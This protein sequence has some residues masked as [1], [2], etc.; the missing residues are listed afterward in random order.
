MQQRTRSDTPNDDRPDSVGLFQ[1]GRAADEWE[2]DAVASHLHGLPS[3]PRTV[4]TEALL[5]FIC[6]EDREHVAEAL[7]ALGGDRMRIHYRVPAGD[8]GVRH[9]VAVAHLASRPDARPHAQGHVIEIT[10]DLHAASEQASRKAVAGVVEGRGAI[11]QAKGV[12]MLA[13]GL[14]DDQ[15]FSLLRWWSRNRNIRIRALA[16]LL[17]AAVGT[18]IYSSQELRTAFDRFMHD[19]TTV[20]GGMEAGGD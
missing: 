3:R 9:L 1:S 8:G 4:T 2:W 15:A 11:E 20:P 12:L 16:G 10:A 7:T 5:A 6:A 18:G 19:L 14:T 17:L 13:Y